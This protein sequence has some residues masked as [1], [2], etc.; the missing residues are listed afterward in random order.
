MRGEKR[1]ITKKKRKQGNINAPTH[2]STLKSCDFDVFLVQRNVDLL[3]DPNYT[4][5]FGK[6]KS[7]RSEKLCFFPVP[8]LSTVIPQNS[9]SFSPPG[10]NSFLSASA[11]LPAAVCISL[12]KKE[13]W[14][15]T[16]VFFPS[17]VPGW[18]R[19][20]EETMG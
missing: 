20:Q 6:G 17:P 4:A 12:Y 10:R 3:P 11:V 9:L 14:V 19:E 15:K 2:F 13:F 8:R 7:P 5:F 18:C 16:S 1:K